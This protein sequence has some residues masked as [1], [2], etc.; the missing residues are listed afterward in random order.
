MRRKT[1]ILKPDHL[2]DLVL[3]IPAIRVLLETVEEP[4]L[5]V[6][7]ST[8]SLAR[9][10]FPECEIRTVSFMSQTKDLALRR[11]AKPLR[12]L[13]QA[14][15]LAKVIAL[16]WD[17]EIHEA[18]KNLYLPFAIADW[19]FDSHETEI[20][21]A[22][23]APIVGHYSRTEQFFR[24]SE[25]PFPVSPKSIGLCPSAG[26]SHNRWP[27]IHWIRLGKALQMRSIEVSLIGG[28]RETSIL[29]ALGR[30]L[31]I[32]RE[33]I[34]LGD[35]NFS[36]IERIRSLDLV[37]ATDSGTAHLCSLSAPILSIFGPSPFR[38]FC[39][40]GRNNRIVTYD[41]ACSPCGQFDTLTANLCTTRECLSL[42]SCNAVLSVLDAAPRGV[43]LRRLPGSR[44]WMGEGMSHYPPRRELP[45]TWQHLDEGE[46]PDG[47]RA[48]AN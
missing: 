41:L 36:L 14:R 9:K 18:L 38:R 48:A 5:Y 29:P 31:G 32:P 15:D 22:V 46:F 20:Q 43:G 30:F 1:A 2:G 7:P 25:R 12:A 44:I 16:R 13:P 24:G 3:A 39:P 11:T 28:P 37:I 40:F 35:A 21:R 26:F 45:F 33:R 42:M 17:P 34:I 27:E 10:L 6:N 19:R 8:T 47:L 4:V 23:L